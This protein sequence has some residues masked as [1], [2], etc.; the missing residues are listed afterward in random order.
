MF[1]WSYRSLANSTIR[2]GVW[3]V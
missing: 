2:A 1:S 3:V